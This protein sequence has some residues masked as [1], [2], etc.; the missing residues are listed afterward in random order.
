MNLHQKLKSIEQQRE[1]DLSP[2]PPKKPSDD[3]GNPALGKATRRRQLSLNTKAQEEGPKK[4]G[5][6]EIG[7]IER[8]GGYES[9]VHR[10]ICIQMDR[11]EKILESRIDEIKSEIA[12]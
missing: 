1:K 2:P 12:H 8:K 6:L 11:F 7:V 10:S 4:R 3:W 5:P 9:L